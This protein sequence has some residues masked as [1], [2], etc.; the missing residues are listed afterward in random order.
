MAGKNFKEKGKNITEKTK[1]CSEER[2]A[3]CADS[4]AGYGGAI[5]LQV[6]KQIFLG[7]CLYL[8]RH[9]CHYNIYGV[10]KKKEIYTDE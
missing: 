8:Q 4:G 9:C 7:L 10:M 1:N 5:F 6:G 2:V 3:I